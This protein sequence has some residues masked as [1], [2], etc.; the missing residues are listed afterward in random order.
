MLAPE[1]HPWFR[2]HPV[3]C[4]NIVWHWQQATRSEIARGKRWYAD[5]HAVATAIADG[6]A[7]LGAGMLA[8]YSPQQAW[9]ANVLTAAQVL[10]DRRAVG[11]PGDGA[12]ASAAQRLAAERLLAGEHHHAVLTGP[13]IRA[14]AHLIEHGGDAYEDC[15]RVVIDRHALSVACGRSLSVTEYGAAPLRGTQRVD[16][17]LSHRHYDYVTELYRC[18]AH[19]VSLRSPVAPHQVQAVTWLV[20]QR[21]NQ[22]AEQQR[23]VTRLDRGRANARRNAERAWTTYR[24]QHL[25]D[26]PACP[27]T[28]YRAA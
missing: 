13:K 10:R 17:S 15:P 19:A 22:H 24:A 11:G 25:P 12:F 9:T 7:A 2:A 1:Q 14:F 8:V 18:A 6:D 28:G 3:H 5:A 26:L 16:G 27:G 21:L 20:R 23:G 4:E